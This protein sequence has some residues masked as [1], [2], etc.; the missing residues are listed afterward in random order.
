MTDRC[1]SSDCPRVKLTTLNVGKLIKSWDEPTFM[2][3]IITF[4][5]SLI[6][7]ID[8][9]SMFDTFHKVFHQKIEKLYMTQALIFWREQ[10]YWSNFEPYF[11]GFELRT[12]DWKGWVREQ[13]NT[14]TRKT[15]FFSKIV[16]AFEENQQHV[17]HLKY[18]ENIKTRKR[19]QQKGKTK[20]EQRGHSAAKLHQRGQ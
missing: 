8:S 20:L 16:N 17:Y 11:S 12:T 3:F 2:V 10:T 1:I 4:Q 18:R 7:A 5:K 19:Q 15:K 13:S 9:T 6:N 14:L